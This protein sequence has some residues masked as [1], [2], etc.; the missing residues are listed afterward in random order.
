MPDQWRRA[1]A[2]FRNAPERSLSF[3]TLARQSGRVPAEFLPC[4]LSVI[5]DSTPLPTPHWLVVDPPPPEVPM[6]AGLI[7]ATILAKLVLD[8]R[9]LHAVGFAQ[10]ALEQGGFA[11]AQKAG[12]DGG[13]DQTC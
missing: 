8:H 9:D 6:P 5:L 11:R 10:H 4:G 13:G 2:I 7:P 12:E 1:A 3:L